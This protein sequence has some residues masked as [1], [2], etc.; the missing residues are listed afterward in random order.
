MSSSKSDITLETLRSLFH[1]PIGDAASYLKIGRTTLKQRCR[2]LGISKWP[3]CRRYTRGGNSKFPQD[4][5]SSKLSLSQFLPPAGPPSY[6]YESY[7][8]LPVPS[9][10]LNPATPTCNLVFNDRPVEVGTNNHIIAYI[11]ELDYASLV[12][13]CLLSSHNLLQHSNGC[14]HPS[15]QSYCDSSYPHLC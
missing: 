9:W 1:L 8:S 2:E 14:P 7:V 4:T 12:A 3:Y 10:A 13:V 11:R 15:P 5:Q 6:D